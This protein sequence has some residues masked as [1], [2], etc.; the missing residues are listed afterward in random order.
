MHTPP[1]IY[2]NIYAYVY[3]ICIP[4]QLPYMHREGEKEEEGK[5]GRIKQNNEITF[6]QPRRHGEMGTN[7][8]KAYKL[9][10]ACIPLTPEGNGNP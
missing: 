7:A 3:C 5:A 1:D 6:V 2:H 4:R 8:W 10:Y 9:S